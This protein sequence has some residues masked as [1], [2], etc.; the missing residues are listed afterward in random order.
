MVAEERSANAGA[1]YPGVDL[2]YDIAVQ[3]Y[4]LAERRRD[5]SH[6]RIDTLL[7]FATTVTVAVLVIAISV[8]EQP[9]FNSL[10]L[11]GAGGAY[12]L[13]VLIALAAK[14]LGSLR[15]ISPK[16]LYKQWLHLEEHEFKL[17]IIYWAGQYTDE[18]RR[19]T[20]WKTTAATVMTVLFVAEAALFLVW[21]LR[22][23]QES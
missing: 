19:M 23:A 21:L 5:A 6:Q 2:A 20:N 18:A 16:L 8:L 17:Q 4:D 22:L 3:S 10:W 11:W 7:S 1:E 9:D 12:A 13:L 14:V 15:Q